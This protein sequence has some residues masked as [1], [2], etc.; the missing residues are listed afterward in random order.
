MKKLLALLFIFFC[1]TALYSQPSKENKDAQA[2]ELYLSNTFA[3]YY[4]LPVLQRFY[5]YMN[6]HRK[7]SINDR[8][9]LTYADENPGWAPANSYYSFTTMIGKES[10][11]NISIRHYDD[12]LF[13]DSLRCLFK[14]LYAKFRKQYPCKK[15]T[16]K[17]L[18][19]QLKA[20]NKMAHNK[21]LFFADIHQVYND[22]FDVYVKYMFKNSILIDDKQNQRFLRNPSSEKLQNDIGVRFVIGVALYKLWLTQQK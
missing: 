2:F 11:T 19:F 14:T 18:V 5:K 9:V 13:P 7:D 8:Y 6:A 17:E 21:P 4:P 1:A 15:I 10:N 20:F 16:Q 3:K 22:D 12:R